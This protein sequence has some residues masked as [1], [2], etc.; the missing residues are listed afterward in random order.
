MP[1][2]T[3]RRLHTQTYLAQALGMNTHKLRA[4]IR[5]LGLMTYHGGKSTYVDDEGLVALRLALGL[6]P[7]G[8]PGQSREGTRPTPDYSA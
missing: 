1:A 7:D 5:R 4:M 2:T 3:A 8:G 6:D